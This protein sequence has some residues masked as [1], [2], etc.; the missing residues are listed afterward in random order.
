MLPPNR[1]LAIARTL[2]PDLDEGGFATCPGAA[3]HTTKNGPRDFR[4]YIDTAGK[5]KPHEH[6][7]HRSCA[8]ARDAL[9]T[10]LYRRLAAA[11]RGG[12]TPDRPGTPHP[13]TPKPTPKPKKSEPFKPSLAANI[14]ALCPVEHIDDTWLI[15]RSPVAI[16]RDP[17]ACPGLLLNSL[18]PPDSRILIFTRYL[19]QGQFLHISGRGTYRLGDRPHHLQERAAAIPSPFPRGGKCGV[20]FLTAPVTGRWTPNPNNLDARGNARLGRR[21]A[22]C[23]TSFPYLVLESDELPP[24]TW[25]RILVQ[26]HDPIVAISTS[27]G[28]S[29]H[30]LVRVNC[31]TAEEFALQRRLYCR[32]LAP[33][34]AD[35]AAVTAVRLTRLPGCLRFGTETRDGQ[36]KPYDTPHRQT[37]L[38]LNPHAEQGHPIINLPERPQSTHGN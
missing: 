34:G 12:S 10:E 3:Y 26:L 31:K 1:Q 24:K 22:A 5:K 2:L 33:L 32:R 30:A 25:L 38:Y 15:K 23:C 6:C 18:Y 13:T 7:V 29:H 37:L 21:H 36:Y 4:L 17:A 27:G 14:A 20:W 16:P 28:K 35:P 19:S 9:M 8:E 11:E